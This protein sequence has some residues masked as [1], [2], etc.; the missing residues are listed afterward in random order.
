MLLEVRNLVYLSHLE[1]QLCSLKICTSNMQ[2]CYLEFYFSEQFK[3]G[4]QTPHKVR[5]IALGTFVP[6]G[7]VWL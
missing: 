1:L 4:T 3:I 6:L 5:V 7:G 2:N